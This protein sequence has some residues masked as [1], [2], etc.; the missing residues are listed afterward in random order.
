[1]VQWHRCNRWLLTELHI[2]IKF[3][4]IKTKL[5]IDAHLNRA[6]PR[7]MKALAEVDAA[8]DLQRLIQDHFEQKYPGSKHYSR[9]KVQIKRKN[10]VHVA[11]PGIMRAYRDITIKPVNRQYLTIP[12]HAEAYGKAAPDVEGLFRFGNTLARNEFG[13]IVPWFALVKEVH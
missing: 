7:L 13:T 9:D 10:L 1:M 11:V 5:P 4:V 3:V 2:M 6:F 8:P 12:L